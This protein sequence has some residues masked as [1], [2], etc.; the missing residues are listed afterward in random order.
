MLK[1]YISET[2]VNPTATKKA[3]QMNNYFTYKALR[4]TRCGGGG[5]RTFNTQQ[6]LMREKQAKKGVKR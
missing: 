1:R 6:A 2:F 3:L 4:L 5:F